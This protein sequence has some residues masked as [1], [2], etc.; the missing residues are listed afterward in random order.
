MCKQVQL[1][2]QA[3]YKFSSPKKCSCVQ[4]WGWVCVCTQSVPLL[5]QRKVFS[6]KENLLYC[7]LGKAVLVSCSGFSASPCSG[8][9]RCMNSFPVSHVGLLN[10]WMKTR[11]LP[12]LFYCAVFSCLWPSLAQNFQGP[13]Q[14]LDNKSR[15]SV[16]TKPCCEMMWSSSGL[17]SEQA[18][19]NKHI[20]NPPLCPCWIF[21]NMWYPLIHCAAT[22]CPLALP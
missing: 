6:E 9:L 11:I 10:L 8:D 17:G 4:I 19:V 13:L 18:L 15:S 3:K 20:R 12:N 21:L 14:K 16:W 5:G 7:I 1:T 22:A 2:L